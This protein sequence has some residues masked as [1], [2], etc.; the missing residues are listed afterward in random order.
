MCYE[1]T[2][3]RL[4]ISWKP[5]CD[6]SSYQNTISSKTVQ[7]YHRLFL[8]W[9]LQNKAGHLMMFTQRSVIDRDSTDVDKNKAENLI[10]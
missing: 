5:R 4:R 2:I 1:S 6:T 7:Y 3:Q 9:I 10:F 8:E